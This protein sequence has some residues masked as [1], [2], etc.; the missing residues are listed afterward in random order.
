MKLNAEDRYVNLVNTIYKYGTQDSV[1]NV[2]VQLKVKPQLN[3]KN[4]K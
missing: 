4:V 1:I 3:Q 2:D